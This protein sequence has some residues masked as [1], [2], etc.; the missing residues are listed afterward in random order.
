M[1]YAIE[2]FYEVGKIQFQAFRFLLHNQVIQ[3]RFVFFPYISAFQ[4]SS[5]CIM[6]GN[7]RFNLFAIA[8]VAIK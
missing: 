6:F 3:I 8:L 7:T 5:L 1:I 2:G 4:K